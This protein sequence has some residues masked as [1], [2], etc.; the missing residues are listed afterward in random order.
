MR[1]GRDYSDDE[2]EGEV[3]YSRP[4]GLMATKL[5]QRSTKS[6][7]VSKLSGLFKKVQC[8]QESVIL[9]CMSVLAWITL[10][11]VKNMYN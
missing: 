8:V 1:H 5:A 9:E 10:L 4:S 2:E 7:P 6:E 3:G 11:S